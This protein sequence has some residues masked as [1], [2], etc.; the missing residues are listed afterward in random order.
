MRI[1]RHIILFAVISVTLFGLLV[2]PGFASKSKVPL[3]PGRR[4]I[5]PPEQAATFSTQMTFTPVATIYLPI[6]IGSSSGAP[7]G[8]LEITDLVPDGSDEFVEITN[9]G[10]TN[11][12][13]NGWQIVSVVGPADL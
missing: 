5:Q 11:Q 1:V 10:S 4:P 13:M 7:S 6:V 8:D 9:N 2:L 12:S 3:S